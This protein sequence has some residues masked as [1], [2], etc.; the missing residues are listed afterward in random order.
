MIHVFQEVPLWGKR[1]VFILNV[2]RK[3]EVNMVLLLSGSNRNENKHTHN[4]SVLLIS[5]H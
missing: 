5:F 1:E 3:Y 2:K 4:F